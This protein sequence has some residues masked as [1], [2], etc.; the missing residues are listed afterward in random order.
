M[1]TTTSTSS[2]TMQFTGAISGLD[3]TS[4]IQA[5]LTAEKAPLTVIA[6]KRAALQATQSAYE[7]LRTLMGTLQASA[8]A[9]TTSGLGGAR[10]AT[11]GN[12]AVFTASAASATVAGS[13]TVQV[14]HLATSTRAT[15][16]AAIGTALTDADLDATVSSLALAGTMTA[17]NLGIVVDGKI[18]N[19]TI[20]A[21]GATTLRQVTDAIAAAIQSQVRTNEGSG[22]TTTVTASIVNNKLQ[23]SLSGSGAGHTVSFGVGGD[24]SNANSILGLTGIVAGT[25]SSTSPITGLTSLGVVRTSAALDG[26]GLTG[27]AATSTGTLT[28]NGADIAYDS[29]K[30]TL[31]TL[32]T[33]INASSSGVIASID[34]GN[35]RL[36]LTSRSG[37]SAPI[38]IADTGTLATAL[39]LAPGTTDAQQLGTQAQVTID[40]RVYYSNSNVVSTAIDGV[41]ISLLAEGTSTLTVAPDKDTTT[42]AVKALVDAYNALADRLDTLTANPVGGTKGALVGDSGVRGI[43]MGFRSL[44]TGSMSST[45]LVRSLADVGVST[46]AIGSAKGTT[47][48]LQLDADKLASALDASPSAVADLFATGLTGLGTSVGAWTKAGGNIDDVEAS[49]TSQLRDLD[50]REVAANERVSTRQAALEARFAAMEAMLA[51]LQTTTASL[52][53]TIAQQNKSTG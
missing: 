52:T 21:P 13:Y 29:S 27:L 9:F 3:T 20:G 35:D 6:N 30:D 7:S 53:N 44:V 10:T 32:I 37:G 5:L 18:V 48:R 31:T 23:L 50:D 46:G 22:S 38:S 17:G 40:Q 24:T 49:I 26:A 16:T 51:R 25:L 39:N 15:S 2:S 8:K 4:I 43:A 11:S 41:K 14:N 28:I 42:T 19:A 33:R 47:N 1:V 12:T 45:G 34:R 36:V